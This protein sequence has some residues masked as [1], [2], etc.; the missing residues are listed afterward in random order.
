M[1]LQANGVDR[2][3]LRVSPPL[4]DFVMGIDPSLSGTAVCL[5]NG[6]HQQLMHRF[7][8]K[9]AMGVHERMER[10]TGLVDSVLSTI[11]KAKPKLVVIE[12]YS[13][14]SKGAMQ[15]DRIEYGGILRYE[16]DAR[17]YNIV[18]VPPTQL[19]KFCCGKGNGDKTGVIAALTKR[20]GAEFRTNDEY[21]AMGLALIGLCLTGLSD[22]QT[23]AQKDVITRIGAKIVW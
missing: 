5:M 3:S 21:D 16:L 20:Y 4:T 7:S 14:A 22:P 10:F 13:F 2:E 1:V 12:G 23:S 8:S 11:E 15:L 6:D 17:G 19:K 18:E 9:P